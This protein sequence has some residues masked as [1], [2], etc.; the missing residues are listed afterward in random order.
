M[1]ISDLKPCPKHGIPQPDAICCTVEYFKMDA[2]VERG[3]EGTLI[4]S[5]DQN[6]IEPK[7]VVYWCGQQG[8][9]FEKTGDFCEEE[10]GEEDL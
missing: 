2:T 3:V 6:D 8:E 9:D 4:P 10:L 1:K 5:Y 7:H